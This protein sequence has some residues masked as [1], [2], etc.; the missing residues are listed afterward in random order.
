[1]IE[2]IRALAVLAEPPGE[3]H[4]GVAAA[5]GLPLATP[6]E[7]TELFSFQLFPYA[8]VILGAEGKLGGDARDRVAGFFRALGTPPPAGPDHLPV[9]LAAYAN[10]LELE[11]ESPEGPWVRAREAMLVE[12]LLPWLPVFLA[13]VADLGSPAQRAWAA[14]ADEV[15]VAQVASTPAS[16]SLLPAALADV[17]ALPD[18]R[19]DDVGAF[20]DGLLAPGRCGM[21]LA[22][23]D[24]ARLA[25]DM[26]LGRRVAER[27]FV[28]R[29]FLDQDPA[30]VLAWLADEARRTRVRW[31]SHPLAATPTL[32]WWASRASTTADLLA[33]LADE[34]RSTT[35]GLVDG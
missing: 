2:L 13:R 22:G 29:S 24:L 27:R 16:R 28:L 1:M 20:M 11:Q 25:A 3:D 17:P 35:H 9:L 5:L 31:R 30:A 26:G 18:P 4:V 19:Q 23:A 21:V 12:H 8:S 33:E 14:L 6:A 15:I 7:H 34:A 10:L 32:T